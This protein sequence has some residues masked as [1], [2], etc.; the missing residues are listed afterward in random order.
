MLVLE[1]HA[2]NGKERGS[3]SRA[4]GSSIYSRAEVAGAFTQECFR[5]FKVSPNMRAQSKSLKKRSSKKVMKKL[6]PCFCQPLVLQCGAGTS[7]RVR[8]KGCCAV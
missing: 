1:V 3:T 8:V 4:E 7:V 6:Q 2:G 5:V